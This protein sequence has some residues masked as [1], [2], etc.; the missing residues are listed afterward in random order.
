MK[1][2]RVPRIVLAL[3]APVLCV[4]PLRAQDLELRFLDVGQGDAVLIQ[5]DDRTVLVDAGPSDRIVSQLRAL[6][7]TRVDLMIASHNHADHIG[8][9]DALLEEM[10][11][12]RYLANGHPAATEIQARVLGLIRDRGVGYLEA[13]ARTV[14]L[15]D[16]ELRI[17]PPPPGV[18]A[19][20]QNNRSVGVIVRRG[21]F[22]ALLTGDSEVEELNAWLSSVNLPDVDVLKAA[23]HGSRNGV[24]PLWLSRTK[25]EVVVIS[26]GAGNNY[27]HPH[28][29]ALRYYRAGGRKVYRTDRNG[30]VVIW[31]D[32]SGRY[33]IS[34]ERGEAAAT[35][36]SSR[37]HPSYVGVC[38]PPPPPD[39]DCADIG[40]RVRVAGPDPHRLDGDGDGWACEG[41]LT[42]GKWW[43]FRS[44]GR[45]QP[46]GIVFP[47]L[48]RNSGQ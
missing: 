45:L 44:A 39:L 22:A 43:H 7:V 35:P 5:N 23:H 16:A 27:G 24:T 31:V 47:D 6:G 8:G 15:G 42:F 36:Q 9:M 38:I 13:A 20:E 46:T 26:V 3:L 48:R 14:T 30:T 2:W 10:P 37:C 1:S 21:T 19:D 25:P 29:A 32:A 28:L 11:V 12:G 40:Q 4:L 33:R 18:G 34:A 41:D 17:L